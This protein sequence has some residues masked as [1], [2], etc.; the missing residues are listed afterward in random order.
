V[1]PAKI[2]LRYLLALSAFLAAND[3]FAQATV[4]AQVSARVLAHCTTTLAQPRSTCSQQTMLVQSNVSGASA[5][6][7]ASGTDVRVR[8][9][10]GPRPKIELSGKQAT[11]TF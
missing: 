11:V 6:V 9:L 3:S 10:G 8:Q 1:N 7:T 2:A 5:N 4:A